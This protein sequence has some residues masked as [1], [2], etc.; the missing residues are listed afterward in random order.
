MQTRK[1]FLL[2]WK[3]WLKIRLSFGH[4]IIPMKLRL[5]QFWF[6]LGTARQDWT[7]FGSF[8]TLYNIHQNK[9]GSPNCCFFFG[10]V[11]TYQSKE[12]F[13][14]DLPCTSFVYF[15][16]FTMFFR[17]KRNFN[18]SFQKKLKFNFIFFHKIHFRFAFKNDSMEDKSIKKVSLLNSC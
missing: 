2:G 7:T 18:F 16:N 11:N 6:F 10:H 8:G 12:T 1:C 17:S 5:T 9:I 13:K 4:Y 3:N 14:K 15:T